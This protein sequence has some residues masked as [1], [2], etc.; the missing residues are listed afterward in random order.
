MII[1]VIAAIG[2]LLI[3]CIPLTAW[4]LRRSRCTHSECCGAECD[5][6]LM[7]LE[8]QKIDKLQKIMFPI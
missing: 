7:T 2:S 5:R 6:E 8:E 1:E 3:L 4:N